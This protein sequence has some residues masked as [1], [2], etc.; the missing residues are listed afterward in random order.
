MM[1]VIEPPKV[2]DMRWED[3]DGVVELHRHCF[4]DSVSIFSLLSQDILKHFYALLVEEPESYAAVLEEPGSKRIVGVAFGTYKPGIQGRFLKRHFFRF[5]W[6]ILKKLFV[7]TIVWKTLWI[8]LKKRNYPSLYNSAS[9]MVDAG[10]SPPKGPEALFMFIGVH[11]KWR[12]GGNA[13]RLVKYYSDRT[14][15][16]GVARIRG[17]V[18]YE[19]RACFGMFKRLGWNITEISPEEV[20]IWIDRPSSDS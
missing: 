1:K 10:V 9:I 14:F 16:A 18:L 8:R 4:S 5:C 11:K 6:A 7:S 19:N 17:A 3:L 13:G 15:Q 12:G 2:R 20:C